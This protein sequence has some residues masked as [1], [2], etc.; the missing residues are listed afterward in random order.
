M[1]NQPVLPYQ[2]EFGGDWAGRKALTQENVQDA[3]KMKTVTC[4]VR[5][6]YQK[7]PSKTTGFDANG[8][9]SSALM[10]V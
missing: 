10:T 4:V 1:V 8:I 7:L 3:A 6:V 5:Y 9:I 2:H